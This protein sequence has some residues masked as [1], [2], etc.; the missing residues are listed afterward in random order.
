MVNEASQQAM[1]N[2]TSMSKI[3]IGKN[4]NGRYR[5]ISALGTGGFGTTYLAEDQNRPGQPRCVVKQLQLNSD[6]AQLV[7]VTRRLF[8]TEAETLQK[9][10]HHEQIPELL[11][12]FEEEGQFFLVQEFIP[13]PSLLTEILSEQA[14]PEPRVTKLLKEI[15]NVLEF[16]HAKGVVH[17]NL[18]ADNLIHHQQLDKWVLIN[19]GSEKALKEISSQLMGQKK[20][21]AVSTPPTHKASEPIISTSSASTDIYALGMICLQALTGMPPSEIERDPKTGEIRWPAEITSQVSPKLRNII[22]KM[23]FHDSKQR[24][25]SATEVLQAL[26]TSPA[27]PL[28]KHSTKPPQATP[29]AV[30]T[31]Q[32]QKPSQSTLSTEANSKASKPSQPSPSAEATPQALEPIT[33]SLSPLKD[34]PF[35]PLLNVPKTPNRLR[36]KDPEVRTEPSEAN[37]VFAQP[38]VV[39]TSTAPLPLWI[40]GLGTLAT[41]LAAGFVFW[42]MWKSDANNTLVTSKPPDQ[43]ELPQS[44]LD[45]KQRALLEEASTPIKSQA[46]SKVSSQNQESPLES[47][48]P[49]PEIKEE[50]PVN[51]PVPPPPQLKIPTAQVPATKPQPKTSVSDALAKSELNSATPKQEPTKANLSTPLVKSAEP[52]N[53][54]TETN[55]AQGSDS[56]STPTP[57]KTENKATPETKQTE[58]DRGNSSIS[59][60]VPV[61]KNSPETNK[62]ETPSPLPPVNSNSGSTSPQQTPNPEGS[63]KIATASPNSGRVDV[64]L[65]NATGTVVSYQVLGN[66]DE[67]SLYADMRSNLRG[68]PAPANV[69]F[70]RPDRGPIEVS[71]KTI[72]PGKIEVILRRGNGPDT[73][74]SFMTVQDSGKVTLN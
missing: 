32:A 65:V 16:V 67:R 35:A 69:S 53:T 11:A 24:Y 55:T 22:S 60:P 39:D 36:E 29:P 12:S 18:K 37:S 45:A 56:A 34:D 74:H 28:P 42:I 59:N 63:R 61:A 23:A 13:G 72:A 58:G 3:L 27:F 10:S 21:S 52:A 71:T 7:N 54:K 6:N 19:F 20:S 31:P 8:N 51:V 43:Q 4:L 40:S 14:L 73:D 68:L 38:V 66:T 5:V 62:A 1:N 9:I 15:L 30:A 44:Q 46:G 17:R 57:P 2:K 25:S 48:T 70:Y 41:L 26:D 50:V 49:A 64:S 33:S 47:K